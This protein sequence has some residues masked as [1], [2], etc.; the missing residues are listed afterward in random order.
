METGTQN[1]GEVFQHSKCKAERERF[2]EFMGRDGQKGSKEERGSKL[3]TTL[4][5]IRND[6]GVLAVSDEDRE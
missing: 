3:M 6:D 2:E 5:A 1:L 4:L